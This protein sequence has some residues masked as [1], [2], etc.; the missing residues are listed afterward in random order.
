MRQLPGL[1]YDLIVFRTHSTSDFR[2]VSL[3]GDPVFIYTGERH[4][5]FRYTYQQLT[6]QIMAGRVLYD[7]E[8]PP[9]F[10]VGPEF[11]RQT[12]KGHFD[13]THF[14]I[15]GCDSLS[16][17]LLAEALVE[18]GAST[19]IGWDGLVDLT[20]NDRALLNIVR[21]LTVEDATPQEAVAG[22]QLAIGSDPTFKSSLSYFIP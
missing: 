10:I 18:R 6:R 13:G 7:E 22:T 20:H 15:G 9:L 17:T 16:S 5:R 11:V 19:V 12:M 8:A 14:I 1:G 3:P 4:N 21:L 2:N